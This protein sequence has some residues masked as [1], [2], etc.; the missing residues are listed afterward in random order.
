MT[1]SVEQAKTPTPTPIAGKVP[2]AAPPR[3]TSAR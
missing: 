3:A 1:A 2:V